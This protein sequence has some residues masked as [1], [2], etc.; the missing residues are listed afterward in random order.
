MP[1][2]GPLIGREQELLAVEQALGQSRVVTLTGVGGCGKTRVARELATRAA[3]R[4]DLPDVVCVEL[5]AVRMA[6]HVVDALLRTTGSRERAGRAQIDVLLHRLGGRRLLL[7]IDNCEHVVGEVGRVAA[8][9]VRHAPELRVLATSREPLDLEE[10]LV[11]SLSP[12]SLPPSGTGDVAA[13][14]RSDAGRFFVDRAAAVA[15]GFALTPSTA[16]AVVQICQELDGLPLALGLAASRV[17]DLTPREIADGLSRRGRLEGG[18]DATAL[19]QHRSVRASLHWSYGLL[20][21]TERALLRGL[22]ALAGTWDAAAARSVALPEASEVEVSGLLAS[23]AAKGLILAVAQGEP[24]RWGSMQT[25]ADY[26]S[27]QLALHPEQAATVRDRQL[28]WF[29]AF[30]AGVDDLLLDPD[31]QRA[32]DQETPNL[33]LALEH[34]LQRDPEV[35]FEMVGSLLRHWIL[36]EH[37]EEGRSSTARVLTIADEIDD[38]GALAPIHLGGALIAVLREDYAHA[39]ESLQGGLALMAAVT[40]PVTR[41]R[42]LQMAAMVLILTGMDL[43]EGVRSANLAAELMR[44]SGDS[45]GRAW[46]LVNVTMAEG[47]CDRFDAARNAY[48]EFLMVPGAGQH[49]RLRTWAELAATWTEL[50]VGSP[51]RALAHADLALELEGDWPSMTHFI[52]TG[53]RVHA[54]ALLGRSE[55]ALAVG[56]HGLARAGK[57]GAMM[58]APGIEMALAI[59]SLMAGELDRAE[60]RAGGLL[61]MPQIHTV[62]L[63]REVLARIALARGDPAAAAEHAEQLASLAERSG[64]ARHRA[65][66]DYLRGRA[67]VLDGAPARG[68]D[69]VQG[70][71]A[72]YVELGLERGVADC[73]EELGLIAATTGD[74]TRA[75]RLVTAAGQARGR[76]TCTSPPSDRARID[77]ARARLTARDAGGAWEVA[78]D[79]GEAMTLSEAIAYARRSRGPRTRGAPPAGPRAGPPPPPHDRSVQ[80]HAD[81]AGGRSPRRHR[82]L[83]PPDRRPAVHGAQ[84]RQDAPL[85]RVPEARR[86]QSNRACA[87]DGRA[88]RRSPRLVS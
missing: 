50:I 18:Y 28:G 15:P 58:A 5:S 83:E 26:A 19:P 49:A 80:S 23:L 88:A 38:P 56:E 57:S 72:T 67:A 74:A 70:A 63:T 84:H 54:L 87:D 17:V 12:L 85:E 64:S 53:F 34:A 14:I 16:R 4:P 73:L 39:V 1:A 66:A 44:S 7:V 65:I 43:E 31:G 76:L 75:A 42:C 61:E 21:D 40:E 13:V 45:P 51:Q 8:L 41:A 30:A 22:A 78:R 33:R 81:R 71:L 48:D 47:I 32:I 46:A 24:D 55:E 10:E 6:E 69:L 59:A 2:D 62:A 29:R 20:N 35:A 27:E 77:A 82:H 25:V 11:V 36:A 86:R 3:G 9:L 52:L 60:A 79:E 68:R 37:F